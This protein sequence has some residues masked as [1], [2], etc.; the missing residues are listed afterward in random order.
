MAGVRYKAYYSVTTNDP[1][2]NVYF[3]RRH[4]PD[5]Q[6]HLPK[7]NFFKLVERKGMPT[8]HHRYCCEILKEQDGTGH[9][10]LTGVRGEESVKRSKYSPVTV[11]SNRK[12]HKRRRAKGEE[13][14]L[15]TLLQNQVRCIK[16]KD[17][18]MLY[19]LL[20]WTETD[21]WH[22][23]ARY[24]LPYNPCYAHSGR[25]G[26][27]FCPYAK[28]EQIEYYEQRYPKFKS[29]LIHSLQRYIDKRPREE[30]L[31]DAE[32]F[33]DWWKTSEAMTLYIANQQQLK[34]SFE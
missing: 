14:Q 20:H 33:Y 25:V 27:M 10:C 6:F 24:Q 4:Y 28:R 7:E 21:V 30:K 17:K 23:I 19:P 31:G 9:V 29:R 1:P 15:E 22:F 26:C 3:I 18:V 11:Y 2:D 32:A 16:G 13:Y 8:I 5:V 12:E 34:M